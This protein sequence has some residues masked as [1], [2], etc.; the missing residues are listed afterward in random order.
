MN[1]AQ[2]LLTILL[3]FAVSACGLSS[4]DLPTT[5]I[6]G[7][8][9]TPSKQSPLPTTLPAGRTLTVFAAASLTG[10]FQE[11]GKEFEAA[12]TGVTVNYDFAGSQV[13]RTQ[14]EQGASADVFASA[15]HKNMD[16]LVPENIVLGNAYQDF[17]T[18]RLIVILPASNPANLQSLLDLARPNQKLVLAD[19]SVPAGNYARQILSKISEDPTFG[20][21]FS[22]RVLA[23]VVSNETDVKQVVTKVELGEADAGIVY[24]TDAKAAPDLITIS[25]PE[26]YNVIA[27]YP[28]AILTHTSESDLAAAFVAYVLSP[29]GQA[30]MVKWGFTP[31][32][33]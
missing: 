27:H 12:N 5:V 24:V 10:A 18:N 32:A 14:L 9:A 22:T 6:L 11:I 16:Q 26:Q 25:I 3:I 17:A 8:S 15:D 19:S 23:N 33:P 29:A 4:T 21:D 31:G 20:S 28:I 13:L 7:T 2:V 1:K 30:I